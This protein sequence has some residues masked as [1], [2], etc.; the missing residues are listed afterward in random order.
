MS[1][2]ANPLSDNMALHAG[3][4]QTKLQHLQEIVNANQNIQAIGPTS[5]SQVAF[6]EAFIYVKVY[7]NDQGFKLPSGAFAK[8]EGTAWGAALGGGVTWMT[9]V[10]AVDESSIFGDVSFNFNSAGGQTN[11]N[12][13]RGST[14]IGSAVGAGLGVSLGAS[15]GSGTFT[16]G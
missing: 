15:G 16:R 13:W 12:F 9:A 7:S 11:L 6:A 8:F 4:A 5:P 14:F 3:A 1:T 2:T 10:F